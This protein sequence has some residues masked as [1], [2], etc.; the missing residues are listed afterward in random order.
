MIGWGRRRHYR[1][2]LDT[3]GLIAAQL[4][5]REGTADLPRP[6][7]V[8]NTSAGGLL[9]LDTAA[10]APDYLLSEQ[11]VV[12]LTLS[13]GS[14][15]ITAPIQVIRVEPRREDG[16]L[17]FGVGFVD[18]EGVYGHLEGETWSLFNRRAA[19]R[20]PIETDPMELWIGGGG[21]SQECL[22]HDVSLFGIGALLPRELADRIPL[23][24]SLRLTLPL[25]GQPQP[26]ML[27]GRVRHVSPVPDTESAV[28]GIAFEVEH[29]ARYRER[30]DQLGSFLVN[31]QAKT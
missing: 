2:Q 22:A 31:R 19:L 14:T 4:T 11:M 23:A 7:E 20:V 3:T 8:V 15:R 24:A 16:S 17:Q 12:E 6:L 28:V 27:P 18:P 1:V 30:V 10:D 21:V 5:E 29:N 13:A 26:S 9:L 25:P